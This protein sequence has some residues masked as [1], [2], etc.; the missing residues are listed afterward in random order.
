M[1]VYICGCITGDDQYRTKFL[2]AEN[3]LYEA[4]VHPVNP[5]VCVTSALDWNRAMR[6]AIGFMLQCDGV[7]LLDDW[8]NS[9]G[10]KIEAALAGDVGIPVK[11]IHEWVKAMPH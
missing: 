8:I 9:Q 4:G 2:D 11:S 3:K 6:Q 10:A 7:A 1:K 5:A